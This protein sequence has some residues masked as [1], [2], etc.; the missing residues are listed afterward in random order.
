[1]NCQFTLGTLIEELQRHHASNRL[2]L[3]KD[4][5]VYSVDCLLSWRGRYRELTINSKPVDRSEN[6]A[7]VGSFLRSCQSAVGGFF[8]GWKGGDFEMDKDTAVWADNQGVSD[9]WMPYKIS[10]VCVPDER[11][12]L[13]T[14]RTVRV[15]SL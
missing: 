1:M 5:D 7:T 12:F 8:E 15:L 2:V 11:E 6:V 14:I 10:S 4:S 13:T 9:G 3:Q